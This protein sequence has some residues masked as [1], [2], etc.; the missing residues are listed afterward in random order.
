M[1]RNLLVIPDIS[2]YARNDSQKEVLQNDLFRSLI[3]ALFCHLDRQGEIS[4]LYD[5]SAVVPM[6]TNASSLIAAG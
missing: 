4:P 1:T 2:R 5:K 3:K 6:F